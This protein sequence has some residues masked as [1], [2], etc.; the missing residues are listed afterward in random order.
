MI[1]IFI[2]KEELMLTQTNAGKPANQ[3]IVL[4]I[5]NVSRSFGKTQ[6]LKDLSM[7]I[8]GGKIIGLLGRNGAGKSTLLRIVGGMHEESALKERAS[9]WIA[10]V[11]I[12]PRLVKLH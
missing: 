11:G 2:G 4:S 9:G 5:S 10:Q 1:T 8:P 7:A 12:K 3:D 6:A